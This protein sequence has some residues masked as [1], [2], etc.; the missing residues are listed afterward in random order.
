MQRSLK[1]LLLSL[2]FQLLRDCPDLAYILISERPHIS[3][4]YDIGDW[5]N[6]E[7][8]SAFKQL[9]CVRPQ[10]A[11]II[12][13]GLDEAGKDHGFWQLI[14]AVEDLS[15]LENVKVC[16]S[17]RPE[18]EFKK[19]LTV[20]P[21]L[22]LED[23]TRQDI[24][25][26]ARDALQ[27]ASLGHLERLSPERLDDLIKITVFGAEGVFLWAVY[28][29]K[30]LRNGLLGH[31]SWD[32]LQQRLEKL[33]QGV[34]NLYRAMWE[35]LNEN[36]ELWRED[37]AWYFKFVLD[38]GRF[39]HYSQQLIA[40]TLVKSPSI[41]DRIIR[42]RQSHDLTEV[43]QRCLDLE[44]QIA[45]RCAGLLEFKE[46]SSDELF[47]NWNNE[48]VRSGI[49]G[50][51]SLIHRSAFHFLC[52]TPDGLEILKYSSIADRDICKTR[53][54]AQIAL[55]WI[56]PYRSEYEKIN[57]RSTLADLKSFHA[58]LGFEAEA[59]ELLRIYLRCIQITSH[60]DGQNPV[61]MITAYKR[62]HHTSWMTTAYFRPAFAVDLIGF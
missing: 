41:S 31:D 25:K 37:T 61:D 58:I 59:L 36:K 7:L 27:D 24:E 46:F 20:Y 32:I 19:R 10:S 3:K 11:C 47:P 60:R 62:S 48:V 34:E 45:V 5:A 54:L 44:T 26:L 30:S 12:I 50:E 33:P 15:S 40:L 53:I 16:V 51:V 1:G 57:F 55:I 21:R 38:S 42:D 18:A 17:S 8:I 49:M 13:D 23:L 6:S 52:K 43:N 14:S 35:R 22:R 2:V 4:Y 29:L 39:F 56:I 9:T 28:V